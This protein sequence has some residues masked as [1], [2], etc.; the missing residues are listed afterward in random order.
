MGVARN[1]DAA[2]IRS[3]YFER[4]KLWHSDRFAGLGLPQGAIEHAAQLFARLE[5]AYRVLSDQNERKTYDYIL[6]RKAK[7]LPTDPGVI[8]EAEGLFKRG[9][10]L[11]RRGQAGAAE[12][13]L[14]QALDLNPGEAEFLVYHGFALYSAQGRSSLQ[15]AREEIQ[16]GIEMNPHLDAGPEFL[17]RIARLEENLAEAQK[18]LKKALQL[19]PNNIDAARELRLMTMR[20][21][22]DAGSEKGGGL[23]SKILKR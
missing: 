12:P 18:Q 16:K 22:K 3:A 5:E 1:A 21:S 14:R 13:I 10:G 6:D 9:Q 7:G 23:L 11:V 8:M 2:T 15:Q 17:G 20:G 4:A 19:N